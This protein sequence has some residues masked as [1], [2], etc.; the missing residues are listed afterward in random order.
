MFLF[1]FRYFERLKLSAGEHRSRTEET[2]R[3]NMDRIDQVTKE[4][5][6]KYNDDS[7]KL[8]K[9]GTDSIIPIQKQNNDYED[10]EEV[11]SIVD[12]KERPHSHISIATTKSINSIQDEI[13]SGKG[14]IKSNFSMEPLL[15]EDGNSSKSV[16]LSENV[17]NRSAVDSEPID[18]S[19]ENI[20]NE[21]NE[22]LIVS[23][24]NLNNISNE[25]ISQNDNIA[26]EILY[27]KTEEIVIETQPAEKLLKSPYL[28]ARKQIEVDD[29]D[30]KTDSDS[31]STTSTEETLDY[32]IMRESTVKTITVPIDGKKIGI[33]KSIPQ[34]RSTM[35]SRRN[36]CV[37]T[38]SF[39]SSATTN[40]RTTIEL[41]PPSLRK[42]ERPRD[43]ST[44]CLNQLDSPNWETTMNGLQIFVRL[45]RNHPE[46]IETNV[47]TYCVALS[48]Q[49]K[50]LRSQV[51]RL[52]C[53]ASAEFFQSHAKYL[54]QECEGIY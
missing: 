49:V 51:S 38:K 35:M 5:P 36:K 27:E 52:A 21:N 15:I 44:N 2:N 47:H 4:T 26:E 48:K 37:P 9:F 18:T 39:S 22:K 13:D 3:F 46:I 50:N 23:D 32:P 24:S 6:K 34:N 42:F 45:I 29:T 54:E 28:V 17:D 1:I 7:T 20:Q 31:R 41:F 10:V 40:K 11:L 16:I 8:T 14:V 33:I 43:A 53:Q 25:I 30:P 19:L 12:I